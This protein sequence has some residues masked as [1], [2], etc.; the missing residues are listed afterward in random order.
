MGKATELD[1]R[2]ATQLLTPAEIKARK[3]AAEVSDDDVIA[4]LDGKLVKRSTPVE[5]PRPVV[6]APQQ[7]WD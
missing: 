1:D 7:T 4:T 6:R 5:A 3:T 2:L